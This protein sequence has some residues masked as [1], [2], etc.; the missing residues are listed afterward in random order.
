MKLFTTII[1]I[2]TSLIAL[3]QTPIT[4]NWI[5]TQETYA[6]PL[7]N[8]IHVTNSLPKGGA[9]YTT[10]TGH[11]YSYV[12]FWH[13]VTNTSDIPLELILKFPHKPFTIFPSPDS[14]IRLFLPPET[15]TPKKIDL[16]DYG[17]TNLKGFLDT[18]FYEPSNLGKTIN[19]K[20]E[21]YFYVSV[22]IYQGQGSARASLIMKDNEF[23]YQIKIGSDSAVI[24]CGQVTFKD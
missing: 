4:R 20:E 21:Y 5:H 7:G 12:I 13:R 2:S 14:H 9:T 3:A 17:V 1:F 10:V 16:F 11:T 8:S 15:M 22:L 19:P 18:A 24:P 23:L 6:D